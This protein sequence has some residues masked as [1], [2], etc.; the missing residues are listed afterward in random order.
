[1]C[2]MEHTKGPK[3]ET[4]EI[5]DDIVIKKIRRRPAPGKWVNGTIAGHAFSAL[6]FSEHAEVAEYELNQSRISKLWIKRLADQT[7]VYSWDRGLGTP[8]EN[9][10]VEAIIDFLCDGLAEY[11]YGE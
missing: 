1:M 3:M 11:V 8:A 7:V 2:V 5:G 4:Q 6:V 9:N 10:T